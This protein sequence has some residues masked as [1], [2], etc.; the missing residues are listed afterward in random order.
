[1]KLIKEHYQQLLFASQEQDGMPT[2]MLD[3]IQSRLAISSARA[4]TPMHAFLGYQRAICTLLAWRCQQR[5]PG[6]LPQTRTKLEEL[7]VRLHNSMNIVDQVAQAERC[8][9][10]ILLL[11]LQRERR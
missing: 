8:I 3:D 9:A 2:G 7:E 11:E 1:L 6:A 10:E 4:Q 5:I